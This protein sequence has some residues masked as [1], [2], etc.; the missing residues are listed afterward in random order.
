MKT[1]ERVG[2]AKSIKSDKAK[3]KTVLKEKVSRGL[4]KTAF[5]TNLLYAVAIITITAW[6]ISLRLFPFGDTFQFLLGGVVLSVNL[7]IFKHT[8]I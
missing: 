3:L 4:D 6:I 2:L 1:M 8:K 7:M 5:K